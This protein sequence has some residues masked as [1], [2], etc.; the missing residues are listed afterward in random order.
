M[1]MLDQ[2]HRSLVSVS[3]T[4]KSGQRDFGFVRMAVLKKAKAIINAKVKT[5]EIN[6]NGSS[7][8]KNRTWFVF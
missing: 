3:F 6:N 4:S 5:G 2:F 1:K 8:Y 7:K